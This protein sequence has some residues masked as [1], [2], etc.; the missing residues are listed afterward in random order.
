M[1][2]SMILKGEI[3]SRYEPAFFADVLIVDPPNVQA[4]APLGRE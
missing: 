3:H 4:L 1:A 2:R